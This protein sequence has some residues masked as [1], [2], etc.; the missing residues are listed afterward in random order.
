MRLIIAIAA[1][2]SL[3]QE[4]GTAGPKIE[5]GAYRIDVHLEIPNVETGDYDFS[6]EMCVTQETFERLGPLGPGPLANC[7]RVTRATSTGLEI[8]LRCEGPNTA[9]AIGEYRPTATGFRGTVHL[10]MGGKNMT[11]VEHQ[12]GT[13]LGACAP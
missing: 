10:N 6:R 12:R 7:P 2:A 1:A 5:A 13:R 8:S 11:L 4:S 3:I 9:Y